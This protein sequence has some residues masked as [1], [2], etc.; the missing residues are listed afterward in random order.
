MPEMWIANTNL[1]RRSTVMELASVFLNRPQSQQV[2]ST[3]W[4]PRGKH[5][6]ADDDRMQVDSLKKGDPGSWMSENGNELQ[7][8][9]PTRAGVSDEVA[10]EFQVISNGNANIDGPQVNFQN[11]ISDPDDTRRLRMRQLCERQ[12][13]TDF[14]LKAKDEK[15]SRVANPTPP[16]PGLS[17]PADTLVTLPDRSCMG[18]PTHELDRPRSWMIFF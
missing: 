12:K 15:R 14:S 18:D 1:G 16:D 13:K 7:T 9:G 4:V 5:K 8:A 11:E 2:L 6:N 3:R 10:Q 17:L